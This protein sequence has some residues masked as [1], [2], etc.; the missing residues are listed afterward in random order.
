MVWSAIVACTVPHV[1]VAM[2]TLSLVVCRSNPNRTLEVFGLYTQHHG[3][4]YTHDTCV[5]VLQRAVP[6]HDESALKMEE[7]EG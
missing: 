6:S 2:M 7:G 3:H 5:H 1:Q 4:I